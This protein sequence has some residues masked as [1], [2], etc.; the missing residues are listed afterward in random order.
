MNGIFLHLTLHPS[1]KNKKNTNKIYFP[2]RQDT[3]EEIRSI[4]FSLKVID[5]NLKKNIHT[6]VKSLHS[7]LRSESKIRFI[8]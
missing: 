7:L 8:F 1:Q 2:I 4:L 6:I 3:V 5:R